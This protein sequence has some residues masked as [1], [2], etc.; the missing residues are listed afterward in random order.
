[1]K[2]IL[3]SR[4]EKE[5]KKLPKIDQITLS[6]KIKLLGENLQLTREER[7]KGY[8]NIFRVRVGDYRIVYRRAVSEI[9]IVLISQRKEIYRIMDRLLK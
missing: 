9:Y 1:M 8:K 6:R 5:L 2:I 3:S 7:L 4:S